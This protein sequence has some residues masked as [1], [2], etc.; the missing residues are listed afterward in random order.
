MVLEA[1]PAPYDTVILM[2]LLVIAFYLAFK[3]MSMVF[4]TILISV[5]SGAFYGAFTYLVYNQVPGL[6]NILLFAFLGATLYMGYTFLES[7]YKT[8][9]VLISV[10]V[11][12]LKMAVKPFEKLY[13]RMKEKRKRRK[14]KQEAS[15]SNEE[16]DVKEVV[17][18]KVQEE[19]ED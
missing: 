12:I 3:I 5:L 8:V 18:D 14:I 19:D 17:L 6:N 13:S 16:K 15:S 9:T 4:E 11:K 2:G 7:A 10:P 1:V